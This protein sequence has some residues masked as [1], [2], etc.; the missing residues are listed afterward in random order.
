M[1]LQCLVDV[2]EKNA[3]H[4]TELIAEEIL[5]IDTEHG[6][7]P[8][9]R[10]YLLAM[11]Y[12]AAILDLEAKKVGEPVVRRRPWT[13]ATGSAAHARPGGPRL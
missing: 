13:N 9:D 6:L 1:D 8:D 11:L 12:R 4:L 10:L 5:Q 3:S 2:V 7:S